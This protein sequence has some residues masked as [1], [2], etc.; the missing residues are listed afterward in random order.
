[1]SQN[2]PVSHATLIRLSDTTLKLAS[3]AEDIRGR[4]VLD[5]KKEEVGTVHDLL[6]DDREKRV[7][8]LLI[9]AGG[10]LGL[11]ARKF[12][13]PVDAVTRIDQKNVYVNLSRDHVAGA[14][15]YDPDLIDERYLAQIYG[16]YGLGPFW[17]P[18]YLYPS[19]PF[20][21]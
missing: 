20:Y 11:G 16:Y 18:G 3:E 2:Q 1:M 15:A 21:V 17:A 4:R 14:P 19:F 5:S 13:I 10:F 6:I 8:F 12:L 9:E 7:R